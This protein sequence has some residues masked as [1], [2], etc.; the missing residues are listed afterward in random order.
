[1]GTDLNRITNRGIS[2]DCELLKE[3]FNTLSQQRN[4]NQNYFAIASSTY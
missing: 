1:M 3:I 4:A 2:N